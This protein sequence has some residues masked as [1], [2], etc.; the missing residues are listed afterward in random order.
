MFR[1]YRVRL[2]ELVINGWPSYTSIANTV[3]GNTAVGNTAVSNTAVSNTA[4]F[5]ILV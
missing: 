4:V 3:V 1:H 5:D 2:R